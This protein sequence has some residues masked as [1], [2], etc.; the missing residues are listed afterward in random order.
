[1]HPESLYGRPIDVRRF[2]DAMLLGPTFL[3]NVLEALGFDGTPKPIHSVKVLK[4]IRG[5][6]S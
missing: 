4:L 1:M 2:S 6:L 5:E 3:P